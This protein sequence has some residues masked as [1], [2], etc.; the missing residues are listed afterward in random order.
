MFEELLAEARIADHEREIAAGPSLVRT[1]TELYGPC[2]CPPRP[3]RRADACP[4]HA[5]D[6]GLFRR[7]IWAGL[8]A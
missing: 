5:A 2:R 3:R 8:G 1:L 7:L 4:Q 6:P